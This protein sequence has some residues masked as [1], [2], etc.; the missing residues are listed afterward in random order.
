M[1]RPKAKA[2]FENISSFDNARF[3]IT[4]ACRAWAL[5]LRYDSLHVRE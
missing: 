1:I 3:P 5:L 2:N 4:C